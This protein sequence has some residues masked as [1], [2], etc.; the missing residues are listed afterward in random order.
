MTQPNDARCTCGK[1]KPVEVTTDTFGG[2]F[3]DVPMESVTYVY[4]DRC[5][6]TMHEARDN[7]VGRS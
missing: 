5:A 2:L 3:L 7:A 4:C 6:L 1:P